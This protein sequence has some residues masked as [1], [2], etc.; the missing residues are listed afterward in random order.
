M[1]LIGCICRSR[2]Q[3]VGFQNAIFK[4]RVWNY[5]AQ[6]FHIWYIITSSRSSLPI[7][8]YI[9]K[10]A[11]PWPFPQVSDLGPFGPSCSFNRFSGPPA[12]GHDSDCCLTLASN[13]SPRD[14]IWLILWLVE[15]ASPCTQG[16]S[17][18]CYML[19]RGPALFIWPRV[20]KIL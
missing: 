7:F 12:S 10:M 15:M 4:H 11:S 14:L 9:N 13:Q 6:S 1:I 5:K 19:S 17:R 3:K 20:N 18:S 16:T 8:S 2:G